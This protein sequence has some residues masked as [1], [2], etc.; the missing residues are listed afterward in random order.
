MNSD[1]FLSVLR[2]DGSFYH[3]CDSKQKIETLSVFLLS[4][5]MQC[6]ATRRWKLRLLNKL[7]NYVFISFAQRSDMYRA[8]NYRDEA[9]LSQR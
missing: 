7:G 4:L 1:D 3:R 5:A 2:L 8:D 9:T 6:H